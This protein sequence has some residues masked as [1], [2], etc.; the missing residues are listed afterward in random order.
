MK[1]IFLFMC[2]AA[3]MLT[4]C[5]KDLE[6]R[7][8]ALEDDVKTLQQ[9]MTELTEQL[10]KDVKD[11][12]SLI[13]ALQDNVFV[14]GV[15]EIKEGDTVIG[16]TISLS[17]GQ[18]ITIYHGNDG[19]DG[20]NGKDGAAP[21]IGVILEN[22]VYYW[23]VNGEAVTDADGNRIPVNSESG[24]PQFKYENGQWWISVDGKQWS[25]LASSAGASGSCTFS[26]V[27]YD[28][29][30]VTFVLADGT[31]IVLPR[32]VA[33]SLNIER[34]QVVVSP[35]ETVRIAY[36]ITGATETTTVYA[37]ADGGYAAKVEASGISAGV[38]AITTPDPLTDGKVVVLAGDSHNAALATISF[39]EG[40]VNVDQN[41][42]KVGQEGGNIEI[43]VST[44][45]DYEV[46][47]D[48]NASWLTYV[49]TK[50]MR[51]EI[52]VL[53]A[54]ANNSYARKTD[55]TLKSGE[56]V[57]CTFTVAQEGTS[58]G[59]LSAEDLVGN[60]TVTY[61]SAANV[62]LSFT[63]P[64]EASDDASKGNLLLRRWFNQSKASHEEKIYATFDASA[65]TLSIADGQSISSSYND[66]GRAK[67][68][69]GNWLDPIVFTVSA[70]GK[71]LS[72]HPDVQFG[73]Y[74]LG[75]FDSFGS[76]YT[77]TKQE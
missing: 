76:N 38:I 66:P 8:G 69:D 71:T 21:E 74:Y 14:T 3:L 77:L 35:G 65:M 12:K 27:K 40:I 42:F 15:T 57:W 53:E 18:A 16:Y 6:N 10:N 58:A 56:K 61:T 19:K 33:F 43:P 5:T 51:N 37:M 47:I 9:Q 49:Q 64:V 72:I 45:C 59:S 67:D 54:A 1:K 22:G 50:T 44:N 41:E 32:E 46:S 26:N 29:A 30:T 70:D 13:E 24:S 4:S 60:W 63:M 62:E 7:V 17:K 36:T 31:E 73:T 52:I 25:S 2:A 34:S 39:A 75:M 28:D 20:Q 55:V 48:G 11:L 23:A 68:K